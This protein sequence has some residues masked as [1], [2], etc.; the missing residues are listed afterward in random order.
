MMSKQAKVR[1]NN[2]NSTELGKDNIC[3]SMGNWNWF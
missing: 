2:A 1:E 3:G